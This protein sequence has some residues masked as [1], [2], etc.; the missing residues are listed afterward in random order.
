MRSVPTLLA[1]IPSPD[2]GT[3][4]I[5]PLPLHMYG[6]LLAVGVLVAAWIAERRW[7]A[8]GGDAK[9]FNDMAVWIVVGGIV[10][11]RVYH[12]ISDYQLFTDDWL[13]AFQIWKGGLS[14]WGV[15]AGGAIAVII[16]TRIKHVGTLV[17]MD[18]IAPGLLAAQ[19]IGRWG[20]YFNQE[21][22]GGPT[23]L[24]WGLEISP[25]KRPPGYLH[26]E[27][28]H[29]TFLYESLYC[30][31][32]LGLLLA[33]ERR[34]RLRK[35]QALALY[36]ATYTFGR[37]FFENLRIDPAHEIAGLRVNAW[38]S[39][40]VCILSIAWFLWLGRRGEE[41][42]PGTVPADRGAAGVPSRE[43]MPDRVG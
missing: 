9:T 42:P 34:F 5:G 23:D 15:I 21:L 30:L 27:T 14:I 1:S 28:F 12:V 13:R 36:L 25:A 16:M 4:D 33:V 7:T 24:P 10:G 41:Y 35:G 43:E 31:F 20:N 11:A 38:V 22:F 40:G 2:S 26:V 3:V 29:P 6:L 17:L 8:R 39:A 18:C 19:A 32:L 37:F